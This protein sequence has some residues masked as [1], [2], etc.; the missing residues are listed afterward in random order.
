MIRTE[1][2]SYA[3]E[4]WAQDFWLAF[5]EKPKFIR[6]VCKTLMGKYAWRELI[7]MKEELDLTVDWWY[8]VGYTINSGTDYKKENREFK[9]W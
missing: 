6:W 7:G 8:S 3:V 2:N 1:S 4:A 9:N 5:L